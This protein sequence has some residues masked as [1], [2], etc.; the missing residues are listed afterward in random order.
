MPGERVGLKHID[1]GV[2]TDVR[3]RLK[4]VESESVIVAIHV[5]KGRAGKFEFDMDDK[6]GS[7]DR[8]L[9]VNRK[10]LAK[11]VMVRE[12]GANDESG[13]SAPGMAE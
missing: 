12:A 2:N 3:V 9:F 4:D 8:P 10:E 6:E 13:P 5:D 1:E 11:S 7:A